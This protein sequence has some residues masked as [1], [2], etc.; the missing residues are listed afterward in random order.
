M[1]RI[2]VVSP[3]KVGSKKK[4]L[5]AYMEDGDALSAAMKSSG[6]ESPRP[7]LETGATPLLLGIRQA[8]GFSSSFLH[9]Y[10]RVHA[11]VGTA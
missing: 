9:R 2:S 4:S 8:T 3:I 7:E 6:I 1:V 10:L 5:A 11:V